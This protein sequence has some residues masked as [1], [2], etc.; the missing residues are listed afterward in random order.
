MNGT[1]IQRLHKAVHF[2]QWGLHKFATALMG[3]KDAGCGYPQVDTHGNASVGTHSLGST[4]QTA[5]M[6]SDYVYQLGAEL[7]EATNCRC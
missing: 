1:A 7:F 6:F 2:D 3:K 4:D 5:E